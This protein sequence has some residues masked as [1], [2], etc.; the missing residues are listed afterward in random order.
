MLSEFHNQYLK[1]KTC[2]FIM[3]ELALLRMLIKN[4]IMNIACCFCFI[5][6]T[7]YTKTRVGGQH[8]G[9]ETLKSLLTYSTSQ[10]ESISC[11]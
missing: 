11:T 10:T 3:A 6:L 2:F 8:E 5:W 4:M 1:V 7:R 9:H